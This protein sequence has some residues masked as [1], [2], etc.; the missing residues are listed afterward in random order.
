MPRRPAPSRSVPA[1]DWDSLAD[2]AT[3]TAELPESDADEVAY[4]QYSSGSTRFPHGVAVTH[5]QLLDNL[6]AHGIGLHVEDTDRCVSWLPWYHDMG[7]VGCMLSPMAPADVASTIMKTEDFARR[8]LAWL[9]M[10]T[11]NPGT[12]CQLLADLRL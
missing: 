4:L 9:D 1:R 10:I 6:R 2:I 5:R 8:P 12:T 3:G 11:R 7:L